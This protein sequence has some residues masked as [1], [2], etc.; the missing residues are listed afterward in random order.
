VS[1]DV[2]SLVSSLAF[3]LSLLAVHSCAPE[4][5]EGPC[6]RTVDSQSFTKLFE[7]LNETPVFRRTC[8]NPRTEAKC[9][10][11]MTKKCHC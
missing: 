5:D 2:S 4:P 1:S 8:R 11:A 7:D 9:G 3:S 6:Y 10:L